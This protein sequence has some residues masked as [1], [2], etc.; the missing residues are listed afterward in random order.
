MDGV[1]TRDMTRKELCSRFGMVLQDTWLFEGAIM[2]NLA[3]AKE[4]LTEDEIITTAKA[5]SADDR[6]SGEW[7]SGKAAHF[8][9]T[10]QE[11]Y[12]S[13]LA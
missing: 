13:P 10:R 7:P 8:I 12:P 5:A 9:V 3:Y 1:N 2:D 4:G 6:D 11:G